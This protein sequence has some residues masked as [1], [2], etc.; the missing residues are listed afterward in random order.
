MSNILY[1]PAWFI[2]PPYNNLCNTITQNTSNANQLT[3]EHWLIIIVMSCIIGGMVMLII[4][5][6]VEEERMEA[7]EEAER[8]GYEIIWK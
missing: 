7:E 3:P 8:E 5:Y 1:S 4:K 2:H 6:Q